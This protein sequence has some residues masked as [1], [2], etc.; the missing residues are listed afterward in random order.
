MNSFHSVEV[1][2]ET[3][4]NGD[5]ESRMELEKSGSEEDNKYP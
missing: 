2:N 5:K 4:S 3:D 1:R